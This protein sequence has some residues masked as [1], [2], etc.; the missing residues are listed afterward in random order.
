MTRAVFIAG[1][2]GSICVHPQ[3]AGAQSMNEEAQAAVQA[4]G[5]VANIFTQE[6][7][8]ST[9]ETFETANPKEQ[10]T[11]APVSRPNLTACA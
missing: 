10:A 6:T 4:V 3:I 2:L 1:F 9:V 11:T 5:P 7:I 8:D